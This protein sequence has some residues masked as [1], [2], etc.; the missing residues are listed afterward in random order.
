MAGQKIKSGVWLALLAVMVLS[1]CAETRFV[2]SSAKR[3]GKAVEK[4]NPPNYK[5]GKPY[6]IEGTWYYPAENYDY[7]ETGIASWY[8]AQFHGR[9]TAN[10]EIYDMNALTAAHRTLPLPSYVRVTN[11][12]NGRS[13]IVRVNDRGPYAKGRIVDLSRR[14]AQLLG[15][16]KNGTAKVR[17]QILADKSRAL[18]VRLQGQQELARLGSPITVDR[19]P[20]PA[21]NQ[22]SL[23]PP[24]TRKNKSSGDTGNKLSL[25]ES[26][27]KPE[28]AENTA[29]LPKTLSELVPA[30]PEV[31][32]RPVKDTGIYV[33]AG[34]FGVYENANKVRARLSTVGA[35][36]LSSVLINGQDLYRVRVGPLA[37]VAEAD[38]VLQKVSDAGYNAARIIVE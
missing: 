29:V 13:L 35:V 36:K 2:V 27:A 21:V 4:E 10:G 25:P 9:K 22:V 37:T 5:V 16:H 11:L 30:K 17:L 38:I 33:Q 26:S 31:T 1:A 7:D 6:Q 19:L 14:S 24:G 3:L 15:L 8:G 20:K 12:E 28:L 23:P 32:Q 34:A 18:K